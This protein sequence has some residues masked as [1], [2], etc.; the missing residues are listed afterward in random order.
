M[1]KYTLCIQSDS[2]LGEIQKDIYA[3]NPADALAMAEKL[4]PAISQ[5]M[6]PMRVAF[7]LFKPKYIFIKSWIWDEQGRIMVQDEG[8]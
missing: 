7:V 5:M 3:M 8:E 2:T 4:L 1:Y 6:R